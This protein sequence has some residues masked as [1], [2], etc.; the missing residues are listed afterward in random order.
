[1]CTVTVLRLSVDG[2][3]RLASN[4]DESP[5][6]PAAEPPQPM[7]MDDTDCLLPIDPISHGTWIAVNTHGLA[8]TLLNRTVIP[9]T[10]AEAQKARK[11]QIPS[12]GTV[13]PR[14]LGCD[15]AERAMDHAMTLDMN[16]YASFRLVIVDARD[17]IVMAC[18]EGVW[19]VPQHQTWSQPM[20]FASSGLG[21]A[22]VTPPRQQLFDQMF[23]DVASRDDAGRIALQNAYH[24]H[25][26]VDRPELSVNMDR[27]V[28]R[29]VS[30]CA[31]TVRPQQ[32]IME[33]QPHAPQAD[34]P[35]QRSRCIRNG[36]AC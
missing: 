4:R 1:M 3:F 14:L 35:M 27:G 6:R 25:R 16:S 10:D 26:W 2:S 36:G 18:D 8:L 20:M 30:F 12:R 34:R 24:R 29:T 9:E 5:R 28:A 19:S 17:V 31:A 22:L 11:Q 21:D 33:Y 13:I 32:I 23:S 15:T 7:N